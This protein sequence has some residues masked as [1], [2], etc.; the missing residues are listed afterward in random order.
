MTAPAGTASEARPAAAVQRLPSVPPS[1]GTVAPASPGRVTDGTDP[2]SGHCAADARLVDK[3]P[4]L[5]GETQIGA[6]ELEYS[7]ACEAGWARVHLYPGHATMMGEAI[8]RSDD[9]RIAMLINPL[10][11]TADV[12]SGVIMPG[13]RGCLGADGVIWQRGEPAVTASI[14]CER[15]T[16]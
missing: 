11:G 2:V 12:Y 1:S 3:A 16:A 15:P 4:M 9:G 14:P 5:R 10:A 8:V 6:L 7:P 13:P